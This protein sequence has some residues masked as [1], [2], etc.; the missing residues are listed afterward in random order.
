MHTEGTQSQG[1]SLID[2]LAYPKTIKS[3][4]GLVNTLKRNLGEF[5]FG[6]PEEPAIY[7]IAPK[8][9]R[10]NYDEYEKVKDQYTSIDAALKGLGVEGKLTNVIAND[11]LKGYV[12]SNSKYSMAQTTKS[13][14]EVEEKREQA[15]EAKLQK[16]TTVR[17]A[18][19]AMT[20]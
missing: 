1:R 8:S 17:K 13:A 5:I 9:I 2:T 12:S 7:N 6:T 4:D 10:N 18:R 19:V 3:I 15:K 20:M 11:V 14:T 16:E